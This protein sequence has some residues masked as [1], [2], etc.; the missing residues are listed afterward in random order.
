[1]RITGGEMRGRRIPPPQ[2]GG[3]RPTPDAVRESLFNLLPPLNGC[4][5]LDLYAG[6]GIVGMEALSRGAKTAV[7]VEKHPVASRRLKERLT[8]LGLAERSLVL[9]MDAVGGVVILSGRE[10][11]F[12]LVFADPPYDRDM[13]GAM[14]ECCCRGNLIAA[15]GMLIVQ[16]SVREEIPAAV[17]G[18]KFILRKERRHGDTVLTFFDHTLEESH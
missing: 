2:T 10:E 9:N 7:F 16:R 15:G 17:G 18:R 8:T 12:D 4:N 5:F 6:T 13:I 14:I 11:R 1:M 3:I